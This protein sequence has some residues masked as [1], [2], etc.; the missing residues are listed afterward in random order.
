M[1]I[2]FLD[3]SPMK[4]A[5]LYSD[6]HLRKIILE[7]TQML[8]TAHHMLGDDIELNQKLYKPTHQNHPMTLW[9]RQNNNNYKYTISILK[10]LF[11]EYVYRFTKKHKSE[12]LLVLL[13]HAPEGIPQGMRTQP[14]L[15]MPEHY[16]TANVFSSYLRYY[17]S[18]KLCDK[19]DEPHTWTNRCDL[20][21]KYITQKGEKI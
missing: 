20:Y 11:A 21:N 5:E 14:P 3:T 10:A 12:E 2:F 15:C 16:K 13:E 6:A 9:V 17:L 1:N 7:I 4:S 8:C 18:E 19:N